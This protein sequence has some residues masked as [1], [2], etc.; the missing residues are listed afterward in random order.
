MD[1]KENIEE[2]LMKHLSSPN[3]DKNT[4]RHYSGFIT[5]LQK[6]KLKVERIWWDGQPWPDIL[7][8]QTRIPIKEI[9]GLSKVLEQKQ[10]R[11]GGLEIFPIGI[12]FP[13]ELMVNIRAPPNKSYEQSWRFRWL[14]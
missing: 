11:I 8:A 12:P 3:M 9:G 6:Q 1:N 13:E 14:I 10:S 2:G 7:V 4:L 5:S